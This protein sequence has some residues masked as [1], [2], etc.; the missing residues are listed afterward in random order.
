MGV[1]KS[2]VGARLSK[3]LQ[4][5]FID[6]DREIEKTLGLS[7]HEIFSQHGELFFRE[8][9]KE[10]FNKSVSEINEFVMAT[11][12]GTPCYFELMDKMNEAGL[13]IF[14]KASVETLVERNKNEISS[15]PLLAASSEFDLNVQISELLKYRISC[16]E[17]A[18][19]TLEINHFT[20]E[21]TVDEIA[22]IVRQASK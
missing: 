19:H 1:G 11:G 8:K 17:K 18:H 20:V 2:T 6:S 3:V 21:R 22:Q 12:G 7:I 13:T 14:L 4:L 5:P 16:Y 9:E 10:F 15:R